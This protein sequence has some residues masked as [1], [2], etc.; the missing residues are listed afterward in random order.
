MFCV[1]V[2]LFDFNCRMSM[3]SPHPQESYNVDNDDDGHSNSNTAERKIISV[4][5]TSELSE[6]ESDWIEPTFHACNEF[7]AANNHQKALEAFHLLKVNPSIQA[8]Y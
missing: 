5:R 3:P 1:F 8:C 6:P 2:T 4:P 7:S